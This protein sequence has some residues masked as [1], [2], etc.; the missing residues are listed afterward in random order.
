MIDDETALSKQRAAAEA[1]LEQEDL[2]A[3]L[4]TNAGRAVVWNILSAC[5]IYS[6][7]Y[8]GGD[9][10]A[11]AREAG[12]RFVGLSLLEKVLTVNS[13]AY[14]LMR[15]EAIARKRDLEQRFKPQEQE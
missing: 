8:N 13:G 3:V 15:D 9:H 4:A 7:G 6:D 10:A 14:I 11:M 5:R 12:M 1:F 2:R